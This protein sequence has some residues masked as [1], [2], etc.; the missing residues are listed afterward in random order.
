M[1][2]RAATSLALMGRMLE[3]SYHL[4]RILDVHV[5]LSLDRQ[6]EPGAG[7]WNAFL[8]LAGW[9]PPGSVDRR[10]QATELVVAGS[11]GPSV[12]RSVAAAR[13]AAQAVRPSLPSE[14]YE[15]VNA[16][17]WRLQEAGWERDLHGYLKDVQMTVH[18]VDALLEDAMSHDEARDFV[19]LGKFLER[20]D[21]AVALVVRKSIEL[22]EAP[23]D[24]L[25]WTAVLKC[26]FSFESYRARYSAPVTPERVVGFLLL[27]PDLPRSARFAVNAAQESVRR[28]DERAGSRP[29]RLLAGLHGLFENADAAQL[30]RRPREFE[31]AFR[32]LRQ[33]L[34]EALAATY[35]RPSRVASAVPSGEGAGRVP[36]Q[37]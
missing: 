7:F 34:E 28:I 3:R 22:A 17:H 5:A 31:T 8:E 14:L 10:E 6:D 11:A 21:N 1:L 26:C 37:Q 18:L 2:S 4:A 35:F 15:A 16:L 25:E 9:P 24:A 36:Q 19:R 32:A 12:R 20:A 23:E 13:T 29:R 30:A 27:D 33:P